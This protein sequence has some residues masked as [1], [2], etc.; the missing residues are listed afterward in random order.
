[1]IISPQ[2]IWT[3]FGTTAAALDPLDNRLIQWLHPKVERAVK[4]FV[5]YDIEQN[6]FTE[7][8]PEKD[9]FLPG[10]PLIEGYEG[11]PQGA[12]PTL[13]YGQSQDAL[14]PGQV[15]IRQI[16]GTVTINTV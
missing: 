3:V 1:M 9:M 8:L 5:G 11:S 10:D 2:D 4:D 15:P 12:I 6:V 13:R 14:M 16:T 7:F